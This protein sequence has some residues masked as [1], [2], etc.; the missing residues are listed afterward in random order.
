MSNIPIRLV[1]QNGDITELMATDVALDVERKTGGIAS[2]LAG[3]TRFGFDL[4]LNSATIIVNGIITDDTHVNTTSSAQAASAIVDFS[5][6]HASGTDPNIAAAT[7][8]VGNGEQTFHA[9]GVAATATTVVDASVGITLQ[10]TNGASYTIWFVNHTGGALDNIYGESSQSADVAAGKIYYI[11]MYRS[12]AGPAVYATATQAADNLCDL[13]NTN[14][15]LNA[16]FSASL[17][18]SDVT[19]EAN[20]QVLITQ[21]RTGDAGNTSTPYY[22]HKGSS[23]DQQIPYVRTFRGGRGTS[24]NNSQMS[25]GD[26][27]MNLY[28]ILNNSLNQ[29]MYN[30]SPKKG[31]TKGLAGRGIEFIDKTYGDYIIAIQIPYNSKYWAFNSGEEYNVRNFF[32]PTGRMSTE[33]KGTQNAP[34]ASKE[35]EQ[36]NH[37]FT[38]IK[39]TVQKATFT[40]LGGEPIYSFTII[41]APIDMIF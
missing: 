38:G 2:P 31:T 32:M 11:G 19:N 12:D 24:E 37:R 34:A 14:S 20:T 30:L 7:W 15:T 39:G 1:H 29:R 16:K 10:E 4:N 6:S 13:I 41:F 23:S 18:T 21:L 3:S 26:K 27:V 5:I 8:A 9:S 40:Q 22:A 33:S 36:D 17:Q 28:G 35:F 25:A